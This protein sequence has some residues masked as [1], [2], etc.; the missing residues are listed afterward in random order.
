MWTMKGCSMK[1][2]IFLF[3]AT[4]VLGLSVSAASAQ[5]LKAVKDRGS[6]ICGVSQGLP[7][8]SIP[9]TKTTGPGSMSI[10]ADDR[11]GLE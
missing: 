1:R 4:F 9:T 6:L 5:T 7:G 11:G 2:G 8:F 10:S 3:S